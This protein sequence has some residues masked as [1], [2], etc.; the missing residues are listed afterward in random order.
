MG[1]DCYYMAG[2]LETPHDRSLLVPSCHFNHPG[3]VEVLEGCF[4]GSTL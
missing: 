1:M 3:A 4:G 2:E